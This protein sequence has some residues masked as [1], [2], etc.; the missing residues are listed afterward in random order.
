MVIHQSDHAI[1][2]F[3]QRRAAFN[4]VTAIVIRDRA[5]FADRCA[6]DM[7]TQHGVHAIALCVMRNSG[8]ELT[9]ETYRVLHRSLGIR[10]ERPVPQTETAPDK[11][12]ERIEREEKL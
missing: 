10:A 1:V 9:D 2:A 3:D 4:P 5:E 6:V 7:P 8:F 12:D 11:V